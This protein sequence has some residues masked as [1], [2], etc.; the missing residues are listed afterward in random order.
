MSWV[1][2]RDEILG[3]LERAELTRV[4]A[5]V[6]LAE[7]LIA[8]DTSRRSGLGLATDFFAGWLEARGA[9]VD[10]I[11]TGGRR[12]LVARVGEGPTRLVLNGHLDVVRRLAD[13]GGDVVGHGDDHHQ[14]GSDSE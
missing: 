9:A 10:H 6:G 5:D 14:D 4:V 1:R 12:C 11:E 2:G 8:Y 3:M 13:A 7:R